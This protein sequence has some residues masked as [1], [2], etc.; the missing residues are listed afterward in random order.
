MKFVGRTE[1]ISGGARGSI[2]ASQKLLRIF[3]SLEPIKTPR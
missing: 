1:D 3:F 2:S